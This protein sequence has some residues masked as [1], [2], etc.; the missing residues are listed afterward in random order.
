MQNILQNLIVHEESP[1]L[2]TFICNKGCFRFTRLPYGIH[3]ASEV[4][5]RRIHDAIKQIPKTKN[6]QD[7]II[8]WGESIA[9]SENSTKEVLD[10]VRKNALKLNKSKC[11]FNATSIKFFRHI[12]TADGIYPDPEKVKAISDM[13]IPTNKGEQ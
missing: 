8:V 10:A 6:G 7:D 9:H 4:F 11:I 12:L 1:K 13:P 3:S 5:Q 2:L